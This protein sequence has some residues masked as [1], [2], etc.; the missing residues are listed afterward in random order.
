[1]EFVQG[2]LADDGIDLVC[3]G[4]IWQYIINCGNPG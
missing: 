4:A 1:M 2:D 3:C